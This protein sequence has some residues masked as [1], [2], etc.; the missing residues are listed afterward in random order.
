MGNL[1]IVTGLAFEARLLRDGD[2]L[3]D[4]AGL[5]PQAGQL[6]ARRVVERGATALMSFGIAGGL[7]PDLAPGTV[8]VTSTILPAVSSSRS[9]PQR[10]V[11]NVRRRIFGALDRPLAHAARVLATPDEKAALFAATGAAA[12]DMESHGIAEIAAAHGLPFLAVRVIA[13]TAH[14][15]VPSVAT[16]AMTDDGRVRILASV[17][18]AL[19]HPTQIPDLIRLGRQCENDSSDD[20]PRGQQIT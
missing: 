14:D 12:A 11:E 13:D 19:C 7:D 18:G 3:I 4:C 2:A 17:L 1:G 20:L 16:K 8:I 6:A 9:N 10:W 5:L 15:R